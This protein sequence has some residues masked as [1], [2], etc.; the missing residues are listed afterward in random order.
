MEIEWSIIL[1]PQIWAIQ[2]NISHP[3]G[4]EAGE[5]L[6]VDKAFII[7]VIISNYM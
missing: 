7:T 1:F 6:T 5:F 2:M 4:L 3:F